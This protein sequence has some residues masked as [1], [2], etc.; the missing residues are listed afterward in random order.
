MRGTFAI[1]PT[2]TW[3]LKPF[4]SGLGAAGN[5]SFMWVLQCKTTH[6]QCIRTAPLDEESRPH[7][8]SLAGLRTP[9]S[10]VLSMA[11]LRLSSHKLGVKLG[12]RQGVVGFTR[13]CK[14]CAT[15]EIRYLPEM[16]KP[17]CYFTVQQPLWL[18]GSVGLHKCHS[19]CRRI[20]CALMMFTGLRNVCTSA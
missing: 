8:Y 16:M 10:L 5:N 15:L 17:I 19:C 1:R 7:P 11:R 4:C 13:G 3:W 6:I 2:K 18:G 20:S 12:R 14:R 9:H